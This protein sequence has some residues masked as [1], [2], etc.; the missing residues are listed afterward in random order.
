LRD[1]ACPT[2]SVKALSGLIEH[3]MRHRAYPRPGCCRGH[4]H[5]VCCEAG[6]A[7]LPRHA[8]QG[9]ADRGH[10]PSVGVGV[11]RFDPGPASGRSTTART[12]A[13]HPVSGAG[14]VT[15]PR[16]GVDHPTALAIVSNQGIPVTNVRRPRLGDR[17]I[18]P[19]LR[20]CR[21]GGANS[22][23]WAVVRSALR[24]P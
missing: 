18:Q 22:P 12:S 11:D 13:S 24:S 10:L 21:F 16:S 15:R 5:Q 1:S 17:Q 9:G 2:H 14:D 20:R 4:R 8:G 7:A 6:S 19:I 3:R 23:A